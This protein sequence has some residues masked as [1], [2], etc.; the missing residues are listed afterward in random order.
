L[1][2]ASL[3]S[4]SLA[5]SALDSASLASFSLANS[6]LDSASLASILLAD[7]MSRLMLG[8]V[9]RIVLGAALKTMS[10]ELDGFLQLITFIL[11]P[12]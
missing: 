12:R 10:D 8:T 1:D 2:S 9:L 5:D 3:A 11:T 6:A 7:S 4:V